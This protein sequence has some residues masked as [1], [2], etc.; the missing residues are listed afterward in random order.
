MQNLLVLDAVIAWRD[1]I[2]KK[3]VLRECKMIYLSHMAKMIE[4]EVFNL[5]QSLTDF[6]KIRLEDKLKIIHEAPRWSNSTKQYRKMLL[7]SFHKFLQQKEI[8]P[9]NIVIPFKKYRDFKKVVISELLSSNIDEAKSQSLT[10][11]QIERF[12]KEMREFNERDF[13]IC[14]TMWNL[15]CTIHQV[16]NFKVN[17]YDPSIG[18]FK[19]S[20]DDFR[21]G[22]IRQELKKIILKKCEGKGKDELIFSTGK[23]KIIHPGQIVRN[24]KIASIRAKLPIIMSPKILY[25]HSI[26]YSKQEFLIM[27]KEEKE[28]LS[29]QYAKQHNAICEK[30]K[31]LFAQ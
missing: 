12:F 28:K 16:L 10:G 30:T 13:L 25:A 14:W 1:N 18:F 20:E 26:V 23:G 9:S 24:M 29:R 15:K 11:T 19:I 27:S 21:I 3:D 31:N 5:E 17:D 7:R 4:I 22:E 8:K 2:L 6:L